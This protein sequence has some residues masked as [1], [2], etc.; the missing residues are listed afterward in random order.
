MND[1]TLVTDFI[2]GDDAAFAQI[3]HRYHHSLWWTA[4]KYVRSDFDAQDVLQEAYLRAALGLRHYRA[5][6]SLKTWL[7]RLVLNASHDY[8]TARYRSNELSLLDDHTYDFPHPTYNPLDSLDLTLTLINVLHKLNDDQKT[9]LFMVDVLGYTIYRT[10]DDLGI[11]SGT[12]K[13]R[14]SRAKSYIRAKHPELVR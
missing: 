13:S 14:R 7:H 5:D 1:Q 4:R 3:I 8:R 9:I 12:L 2:A 10:A 6:C 11:S